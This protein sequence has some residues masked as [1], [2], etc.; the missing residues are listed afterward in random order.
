MHAPQISIGARNTVFVEIPRVYRSA[1][2][3]YTRSSTFII[4]E[5]LNSEAGQHFPQKVSFPRSLANNEKRDTERKEGEKRTSSEESELPLWP[6]TK[7]RASCSPAAASHVR[8]VSCRSESLYRSLILI[9]LGFPPPCRV[10]RR[11][12]CRRATTKWNQRKM[13]G[14]W[15]GDRWCLRNYLMQRVTEVTREHLSYASF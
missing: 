4:V 13:K 3:A 11:P 1:G 7:N 10:I 12:R 9:S 15:N 6:P 2:I 5:I 14:C 8:Y